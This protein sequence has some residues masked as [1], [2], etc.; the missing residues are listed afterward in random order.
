MA[1][2][3]IVTEVLGVA[4]VGVGALAQQWDVVGAAVRIGTVA[5]VLD[6]LA[7]EEEV[8]A[9]AV[10]VLLSVEGMAVAMVI[11]VTVC[12]SLSMTS[13]FHHKFLTFSH[14]ILQFYV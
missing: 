1:G 2:V 12:T 7:V 6:A 4:T 9:V 5:V 10:Q 11:T 3:V 14:Q 8:L 13:G